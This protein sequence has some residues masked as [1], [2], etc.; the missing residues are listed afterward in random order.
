MQDGSAEDLFQLLLRLYHFVPQLCRIQVRKESVSHG[1][2][3][4]LE[5][6]FSE[7]ASLS[8][9]KIASLSEEAGHEIESC[10]KADLFKHRRGRRQVA[11]TPVIE[12][13][14]DRGRIIC[15]TPQRLPYADAIEAIR[16]HLSNLLA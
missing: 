4:N 15:P 5:A 8:R 11:F 7:L 2:A 13:D 16:S 12:R 9:G 14:R 10:A 1:V 3:S 6:T